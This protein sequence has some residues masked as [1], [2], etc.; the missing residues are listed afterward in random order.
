MED[1][2]IDVMIGRGPSARSLRLQPQAVHGR[3]ARPPEPDASVARCGIASGPFIGSTTTR[4]TSW[5]R[6][7]V[8]RPGIL[9]VDIEPEAVDVLA[10]RGRGTPRVVNRL[11]RRVRDYAQVKSDGRIGAARSH[12]GDERDGHRRRGPRHH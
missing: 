2:A 9:N 8:A 10:R 3:S 5:P 1:F 7:S 12:P 6:S 11:L 4:R